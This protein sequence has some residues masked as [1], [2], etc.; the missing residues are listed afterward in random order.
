MCTAKEIYV[1]DGLWIFQQVV[2]LFC[3]ERVSEICA[4]AERDLTKRG[5]RGKSMKRLLAML[6]TGCMLVQSL[7]GSAIA[8]LGAEPDGVITLAD[9]GG[10]AADADVTVGD[11]FT[12]DTGSEVDP[13]AVEE[14]SPD[15]TLTVPDVSGGDGDLSLD[16]DGGAVM[17]EGN[18]DALIGDEIIDEIELLP[19]DGAD[20]IGNE[21]E[22]GIGNEGES[23]SEIQSE[24]GGEL[25]EWE[26]EEISG[27]A[28]AVDNTDEPIGKGSLEVKA[29]S[30]LPFYPEGGL[31]VTV[32]VYK[33]DGSDSVIEKKTITLGSRASAEGS[34]DTEGTVDFEVDPGTYTIRVNA[35]KFARYEQKVTVGAHERAKICIS[36]AK[37]VNTN[38]E[39]SARTGWMRL[40]DVTNDCTIK[41]EDIDVILGEMRT[42]YTGAGVSTGYDAN[43]NGGL[44]DP[45]KVDLADLQLAVQSLYGEEQTATLE[46]QQLP[47]STKLD[48]G[49]Q[50]AEDSSSLENLFSEEGGNVGLKPKNAEKEIS[51]ENPVAVS[52]DLAP[53][54][55]AEGELP[56]LE[57]MTVKTPPVDVVDGK[58]QSSI[59][60]GQV[61][62]TTIENGVDKILVVPMKDGGQTVSVSA[63][64]AAAVLPA[65]QQADAI[66]LSEQELA[67]PS[68]SAPAE[69]ETSDDPDVV[70]LPD[71]ME[72][73]SVDEEV[74]A[75]E[76]E[77]LPVQTEA[78]V[79]A[80]A[81][82]SEVLS[83][84]TATRTSDG[85]IVL[86]FG[87]QVAVKKITIKI[88][89]TTKKEDK[90]VNIA[91][92]EFVNDMGSRIPEPELN[93]PELKTPE[94][95]NEEI[96]VGWGAEANVTGYEV[97]ISGVVKK[98]GQQEQ[99]VRTSGTE[100]TF[101][102]INNNDLINYNEYKIKVRSVNGEWHSPWS[103][104]ITAVPKPDKKPDPV[105]NV[106]I[107]GGYKSLHLSWKDMDDANGYM[108]YY[109][110]SDSAE[111]FRPVAE[112][113]VKKD[114]QNPEDPVSR[115]ESG[116]GRLT[117]NSYTITGLEDAVSYK[118]YVIS[119]NDLGWGSCPNDRILEAVTSSTDFPQ[120]PRYHAINAPEDE[121]QTGVKTPHVIN[122][123]SGTNGGEAKSGM[124]ESPL[125]TERGTGWGLVDNDYGSYWRK[126]DWDDGES[127]QPGEND[128]SKGLT[129]QLDKAYK[130]SYL[131]YSALD[132][133]NIPAA[134][135]IFY[136]DT[137]NPEKAS[138]R[139]TV[140]AK[141]ITKTDAKGHMYFVVKFAEE[142]TAD[143]VQMCLGMIYGGNY[144]LKA[145]EMRF[146]E[147]DT[148]YEGI[149]GLFEDDMHT[150]LKAG[151]TEEQI[152][153]LKTQ[154]ET[155]DEKSGEL[156]PLYDNLKL[157]IELAEKLFHEEDNTPVVQV[158]PTITAQND[159]LGFG[160][161]NEWQPLGK[162]AAAGQT[163]AVYV[164]YTQKGAGKTKSTGDS[165]S[166]KLIYTQY[167][168]ESNELAS[169]SKALQI[170]RNELTV[171]VVTKKNCERGG[172]LYVAYTGNNPAD[173]YEVRVLG[174]V[175]IPVLNIYNLTE[176]GKKA[177]RQAAIK[178]YVEEL[179]TYVKTI[180]ETHNKLRSEAGAA[181]AWKTS[182]DQEYDEKN[183]FLNA[184][185]LMMNHMMYSVPALQVW[186]AIGGDAGTEAAEN[187]LE[188]ALLA[189]EDTMTLFYQHK[190][191]SNDDRAK[192]RGTNKLPSRHL[193][194]RYM[195]MFSGAFMYASGN[196]IGIEY[197]ET[198]VVGAASWDS[199]GWG[200]AHE[201]G[202]DINQGTYAIA[203]I[204][205]NYF[206]QLLTKAANGTRFKYE[207]IYKK[208]T[209]G[210]LGR[211]S[212][213]GIQLGLYWQLHL[214][215]DD[216][217]VNNAGKEN[218]VRHNTGGK[219][220]THTD[221][222]YIFSDYEEQFKNLFF[223]RVDTYSRN[224]DKVPLAAEAGKQKKLEL[225]SNV[226]Q[227]LM[228]LSCAA[229]EKNILEFFRRWGMV[230]DA[231]TIAFAEQYPLET[232]ALYYVN[233]DARDYRAAHKTE[234]AAKAI[235]GKNVITAQTS[236]A[237]NKVSITITP[238]GTA[239]SGVLLGYEIIR[240]MYSNGK[241]EKSVAGFTLANGSSPV[242]YVD[243][244]SAVN[245]RVMYYSVK[246]V[247]QFLN[248]SNEITA[249]NEKIETGGALNKEMWSAETTMTSTDDS[250]V[251]FESYDVNSQN[252]PDSGFDTETKNVKTISGIG[253]AI[254]GDPASIYHGRASGASAI[255]IDMHKLETIASLIYKGTD[256]GNIRVS[257][258]DDKDGPWTQAADGTKV[259]EKDGFKTIWFDAAKP[260][261]KDFWI[262]TYSARYVKLEF[263]HT[264]AVDINEI[265]VCG[266]SGDNLE[267]KSTGNV[268]VSGTGPDQL[269]IGKLKTDW[270][271][272]KDGDK[273]P[274]G[275]LIF[276]G[277]Y[278]G[279]PA[280]NVVLL[281]DTEG[282]VVGAHKNDDG[283]VG[284][285]AK[286]VFFAAVPKEG[287]LGE[288]SDGTWVYYVE[289][290]H[291]NEAS[292][293][294]LRKNG[295][296]GELYRVDDAKTL[297]SERIVSDTQIVQIPGTLPEIEMTGSIPE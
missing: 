39:S 273:I 98:T 212:N 18:T 146:H 152:A 81:V 66:T 249:G 42:K 186:K 210:A 164:G 232:K 264:G 130:M 114:P 149:M 106:K 233:D 126:L 32:D 91:K 252:D 68:A 19:S 183:C 95:A 270:T 284:V 244:I 27:A 103:N 140:P 134:V 195:R 224:P 239:D 35:P 36:T 83:G 171:P 226:D 2:L 116:K 217:T 185:D 67:V 231:D 150:F 12:A 71:D 189:M 88:T 167:H 34:I 49:T 14:I 275:S 274:A 168:A 46:K 277:A 247:D 118:A 173:Q 288:T 162:T 194:I 86:D 263:T 109:K 205:N 238:N 223:A 293:A 193:N 113:F 139:Q 6:L 276:A 180:E 5:K 79:Q 241:L 296:R 16:A 38:L 61:E 44:E 289:K 191:L 1:S 59:D 107:E 209:S 160:G 259:K 73:I 28:P 202:H 137:T 11:T 84:S 166:L 294:E 13:G 258:S 219:T 170:G 92:V 97:M 89:G 211:S 56:K 261:A 96:T 154:L 178:A 220:Y 206:A 30:G 246:A 271:Y 50:L 169:T 101:V 228:R 10:G 248:Y 145:A 29:A 124:I 75:E 31:K 260:E 199:F 15:N 147:C 282:N 127:Y 184:T 285:D 48:E 117:T 54:S 37:T 187:K 222:R 47:R 110:K 174:G 76:L 179:G 156:H 57:G 40:G 157:E 267:F 192:E 153:A 143:K 122:A 269:V 230:P 119:W 265:E 24:S 161:L 286:Q 136:W 69:V 218:P 281:Y 52:F 74:G 278:K 290:E 256:V 236:S 262:G 64:A 175:K 125:D 4:E 240:G 26:L 227:T 135:R 172:Q 197:P 121:T 155:P 207:D 8:A 229:A 87:R 291:W 200:I 287:K 201:I 297:E 245:N 257:I 243:E 196:H 104:E 94:I 93:T 253:K 43:L 279:N 283:S 216:Y 141:I 100:H 23:E 176:A 108:V 213:V 144:E 142:V 234:E 20:G 41:Q 132:I 190:G 128:L 165:T 123:W 3:A 204:T 21:T 51:A 90:L 65:A 215:F 45:E 163:I 133:R 63:P 7:P 188:N 251:T 254:D 25:L 148:L 177:E 237:G 131:T 22:D 82:K 99:T 235:T 255:V 182:V 214:A 250:V 242:T 280:Y 138:A 221:D 85:S 53:E 203:E 60:K 159:N 80:Q 55:A 78:P 77:A 17:D 266:P 102:S 158:D 268:T 120:L 33:A 151:V 62:I 208:V 9:G 115:E 105:D 295:I 72:E 129:V 272:S 112:G 181:D 58:K 198:T 225:G 111:D 70:I 292:L